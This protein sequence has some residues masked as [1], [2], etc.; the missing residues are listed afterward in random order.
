MPPPHR[1][2]QAP[3]PSLNGQEGTPSPPTKRAK[4][5][6]RQYVGPN[7]IAERIAFRRVD[8]SGWVVE[9]TEERKPLAAVVMDGDE[10]AVLD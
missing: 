4:R 10:F 8:Q 2:V 5:I 1:G 3:T 7:C 6:F 9:A